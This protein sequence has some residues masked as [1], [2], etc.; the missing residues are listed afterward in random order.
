MKPAKK[1]KKDRLRRDGDDIRAISSR[2]YIFHPI[3]RISLDRRRVY[4]IIIE[5]T[6]R[7]NRAICWISLEQRVPPS[8]RKDKKRVKR[9]T[10]RSARAIEFPPAWEDTPPRLLSVTRF[11]NDAS[12]SLAK[13]LTRPKYHSTQYSSLPAT[14]SI[15]KIRS[16]FEFFSFSFSFWKMKFLPLLS[17]ALYIIYRLLSGR[18]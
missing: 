14:T 17:S 8:E 13:L 9:V 16:R 7:S 2:D 1:K 5:E 4:P 12:T 10:L 3:D 11:V 18:K 6:V 15:V